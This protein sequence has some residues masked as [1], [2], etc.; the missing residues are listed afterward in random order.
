M[1]QSGEIL[2]GNLGADHVL[3]RIRTDKDGWRGGDIEI[4]CD[5]WTGRTNADFSKG[6]LGRFGQQV[7][8]LRRSLSGRA[9]LFPNEPNVRMS[10]T[11]DGKGHI[12]VEGV[13]RNH[14]H[15][16]TRLEFSFDID[17]TFLEKIAKELMKVDPID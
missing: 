2:I 12:R 9:E 3:I 13:G 6:E 5:G 4:Q 11:G 17:Q 14:F 1:S 10:L 7:D 15:V 8:K 16:G